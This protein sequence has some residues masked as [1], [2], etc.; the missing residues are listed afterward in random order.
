MRSPFDSRDCSASVVV[1]ALFL[2]AIVSPIEAHEPTQTHRRLTIA[3]LELLKANSHYDFLLMDGL[4][5]IEVELE[6]AL[7]AMEEDRCVG[8]DDFGIDWGRNAFFSNHFYEPAT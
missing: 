2:T 5:P 8:V 4:E 7:G 3:A 6:L 1:I